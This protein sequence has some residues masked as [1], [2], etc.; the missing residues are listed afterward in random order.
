M[1]LSIKEVKVLMSSIPM[2]VVG[3]Q[4]IPC[5]QIV[6]AVVIFDLALC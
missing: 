2:Q 3:E 4:G 5:V 6:V 1:M